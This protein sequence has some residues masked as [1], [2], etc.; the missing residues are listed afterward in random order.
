MIDALEIDLEECTLLVGLE[1][2]LVVVRRRGTDPEVALI[3]VALDVRAS[4][5][6]ATAGEQQ[7]V[8]VLGLE[9]PVAIEADQPADAQR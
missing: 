4:T 8:V 2:A 6:P 3:L 1:N 5:Q 9:L 7:R